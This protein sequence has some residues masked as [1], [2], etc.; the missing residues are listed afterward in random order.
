[1]LSSIGRLTA[2]LVAA[3]VGGIIAVWFARAPAPPPPATPSVAFASA[4]VPEAES[5]EVTQMPAA[6]R[7][8]L[9]GYVEPRNV[10]RLTAQAP[11]RIVY[12]AGQEGDRVAAQQLVAALDTDA[13]QAQYRAAWGNLASE[14]AASVNAETQLYHR[15]YGQPTTSPMGGPAYDAYDR[16]ITPF[17]NMA[18]GFMNAMPGGGGPFS[19]PGGFGSANG[20]MLTQQQAQR[21][22]PAISNARTDYERQQAALLASQARIDQLDAALRDRRAVTP[23]AGVILK[24]YVRVGDIVQPGQPLADIGD[25]DELDVVAEVPVAQVSQVKLGDSVPVTVNGKNVWTTVSQIVP[26]ASSDQHTVTV[27]FA[28]PHGVAAA[29]GMYARVWIAQ[30]SGVTPSALTPAVPTKAIVY[31]GSLPVAFVVTGRGVEMRVLRL[32]DTMGDR[33]AVLAGLSAGERVLANPS[34]EL[35]SGESP[36]GQAP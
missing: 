12:L 27:K 16:G 5:V 31:R 36:S 35:K 13:L 23:R 22:Y 34:P 8:E 28:L 14:S 15:L 29:P 20:P 25:V 3:I 26:A 4:P 17:Y 11:G 2:L 7:V 24:R 30:A 33:T 9:G 19:G 18:Q 21:S 10:V 32:G 1:M 6:A